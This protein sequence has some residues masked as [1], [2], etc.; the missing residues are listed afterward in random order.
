MKRWRTGP[1]DRD[2]IHHFRDFSRLI[3]LTDPFLAVNSLCVS[4]EWSFG[5]DPFR[6]L[7]S[8]ADQL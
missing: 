1:G 4:G 2:W 3:S 6:I 8:T 7:W 5:G